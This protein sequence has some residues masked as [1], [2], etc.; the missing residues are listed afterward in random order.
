MLIDDSK[1]ETMLLRAATKIFPA[2]PPREGEYVVQWQTPYMATPSFAYYETMKAA[3]I[4][5]ATMEDPGEGG[6]LFE[7]KRLRKENRALVATVE[8]L[9]RD[10]DMS[11]GEC[12]R[13]KLMIEDLEKGWG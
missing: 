9:Q 7:L 1:L 12:A 8:G 6:E 10:L 3:V 5:A 2:P 11:I 13:L 4:A